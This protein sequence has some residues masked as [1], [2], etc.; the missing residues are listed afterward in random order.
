MPPKVKVVDSVRVQLAD[1]SSSSSSSSHSRGFT[2]LLNSNGGA[3]M[4]RA[5]FGQFTYHS[6]VEAAYL[7]FIVYADIPSADGTTVEE[8]CIGMVSVNDAKSNDDA[9]ADTFA[10]TIESMQDHINVTSNNTLFVNFWCV[11]ENVLVNG[12][13][14]VTE[15][16][17]I[18]MFKALP[19]IDY[20]IWVC[21][22]GVRMTSSME[23][24]FFLLDAPSKIN[25]KMLLLRRSSYLPKLLV[26]NARVEDND[27][28]VPILMRHNPS[29]IEGKDPFFLADLISSRDERNRFFVGSTQNQLV[30]MLAT[31]IDVNVPLI[32]KIFDVDGFSDLFLQ[33]NQSGSSAPVNIAVVGDLWAL[34]KGIL[35]SS[36]D[37]LGCIYVDTDDIPAPEEGLTTVTMICK[38]IKS[39]LSARSL[40]TAPLACFIFGYPR[41]DMQASGLF[42]STE[43][44]VDIVLEFINNFDAEE[45]EEE[46][47][48]QSH[49]DAVE[50][51]RETIPSGKQWLK[52]FVETSESQGPVFDDIVNKIC[53]FVWQEKQKTA[54]S[55]Q[56]LPPANA[57][58]A[59]VFCLDDDFATR[60]ND[61][62]RV[63][64]ED[65]FD[66]DYCM[67]M[68]HNNSAPSLLTRSM[69][70][71]KTRPGISFDQSLFIIH[72][73]FFLAQEHM[74]VIRVNDNTMDAIGEF[75]GPL[76]DDKDEIMAAAEVALAEQGVHLRENPADTFFIAMIEHEIVGVM[77]VSRKQLTNADVEKM[78]SV[79]RVDDVVNFERH[80]LRQQAVISH[81]VMNPVFSRFSR[82]MIREVMRFYGKTVLYYKPGANMIPPPE[83]V[84]EMVSIR[85]RRLPQPVNIAKVIK[86]YADRG[87]V[88]PSQLDRT[89]TNKFQKP[90]YVIL[91]KMIS[92]PKT[93]ILTRIVVI[94]GGVATY[95]L[96]ET[97]CCH[98]T[99]NFPNLYVVMETPPKLLY[100]P[101]ESNCDDPDNYY[102]PGI[103]TCNDAYDMTKQE[104]QSWGLAHKINLVRGHLTDIDRDNR[105]IVI[106]NELI[107][108]YDILVISSAPQ[109]STIKRIPALANVH[110]FTAATKGVF[111]IGNKIMDE[112][113]LNWVKA[114]DGCVVLYGSILDVLSAAG[115]LMDEGV[116]AARLSLVFPDFEIN[117]GHDTVNEFVEGKLREVGCEIRVGWQLENATFAKNSHVS[118]LTIKP[119]QK[120]EKNSL[121]DVIETKE[122]S[123]VP[124]TTVA[125]ETLLCCMN[126]QCDADIFAAVNDS[127][128]VYDGGIVVDESFCTTDPYIF[129]LGPFTRFSRKYKNALPHGVFNVRETAEHVCN[130]IL[131]KYL[132]PSSAIVRFNRDKTM[133]MSSRSAA[134]SPFP[135]LP[136]LVLPKSING[137]LPGDLFFYRCALPNC[138]KE[139]ISLPTVTNEG[140]CV[141][142]I[143]QYGIIVEVLYIGSEE[144]EYDNLS[145]L[146]GL[147]E[148]TLNAASFGYDEGEITDWIE[149]FRENWMTAILHDKYAEFAAAVKESLDA[150]KGTFMAIDEVLHAAA[151]NTDDAAVVAVR[152]NFTGERYEHLH[153]LTKKSIESQT[154][155]FVKQNKQYLNKY[156][157][158]PS[159]QKT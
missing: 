42:S 75:L 40:D 152:K 77:A 148:A 57:F 17:V 129:A 133:S 74:R 147:H 113:A 18:E 111:S 96:L 88:V 125:C 131:E 159:L 108:E 45:K 157:T 4:F 141:V 2:L 33:K 38:N 139:N 154:V 135:P 15:V 72:R 61:L 47:V 83:V 89:S 115:C 84:D 26:R 145:R 95:P 12:T 99:L 121:G 65:H 31:S 8:T 79:Y 109:D 67:F 128:L 19:E 53:D 81:W 60:G 149:Y 9:D 50:L 64:F 48:I 142:K 136:K 87:L 118:A 20:V 102:S 36:I 144:V 28:L 120:L 49:L 55:D 10:S 30:G 155:D 76:G 101:S 97:L 54:L 110:P 34:D 32:T 106:S 29:I 44:P 7:S 1:T 80:R 138:P 137:K 37:K 85:S 35:I 14:D 153:E 90:L 62:L 103:L 59:T 104:V 127:G 43:L 117:L 100:N 119:I 92:Q 158:A 116:S 71:V 13:T 41:N 94:G 93:P 5:M 143:D 63:A 58:A 146:V 11:E 24:Y 56:D 25:S 86:G 124:V 68:V 73:S 156:Y 27:D 46:E 39:Q 78:R 140:A 66:V 126:K 98:P 52:E 51:L 16:I 134:L 151:R 112:R 22:N 21:P 6:L 105:G 150:D 69:V 130:R 3:A 123:E 23:K 132:D 82:F 107:F 91:K 122:G 70:N 114:H